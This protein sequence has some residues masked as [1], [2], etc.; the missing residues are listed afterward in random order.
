VTDSLVPAHKYVPWIVANGQHDTTHEDSI[1]NDLVKWA[2]TNYK[3]KER[4]AA[5]GNY[6]IAADQ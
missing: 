5:C 6:A 1:Q 3:G 4:I 2:C